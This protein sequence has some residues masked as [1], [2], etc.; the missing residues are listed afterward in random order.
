MQNSQD[1]IAKA[2]SYVAASNAHDVAAIRAMLA[3]DC[4]YVSSGV[5]DHSSKE[6]ILAM[7]QAFFSANSD[8]HWECSH[9]RLESHDCVVFDFA[10]SFGSATAQG[11]ERI[12]FGK[13]DEITCIEVAR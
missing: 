6:A 13:S 11:V 12:R 3:E 9:Y 8:V 4:R 1:Y 7:M 2:Q 10:I 5:G